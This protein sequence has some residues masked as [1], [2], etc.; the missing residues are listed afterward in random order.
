MCTRLYNPL[1]PSVCLSVCLSVCR[2]FDLSVPLSFFRRPCTAAHDC[3]NRVPGLVLVA[4]TQSYKR[5]GPSVC[6]YVCWG[7]V[8][9]YVTLESET[10][11][12]ETQ[13]TRDEVGSVCPRVY[14][15]GGNETGGLM[16]PLTRLCIPCS[17]C[18]CSFSYPQIQRNNGEFIDWTS[19]LIWIAR[20]NVFTLFPHF[21]LLQMN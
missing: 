2:S 13:K 8:R 4:D 6:C 19:R 16:P 3:G 7:L 1:C 12:S 21:V 20:K 14:R 11:E 9:C 5:L 10:L 17:S 15:R 18:K